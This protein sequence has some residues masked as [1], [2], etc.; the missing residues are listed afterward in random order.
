[1]LVEI[2][3]CMRFA[4]WYLVFGAA[5]ELSHVFAGL[6]LG[7]WPKMSWSNLL[8]I[9]LFRQ[10]QVKTSRAWQEVAIRHAGWLASVFIAVAMCTVCDSTARCAAI[11]T[12]AEA[13]LSDLCRL[14]RRR[15]PSTELGSL[16][17][18][19]WC[20]N[21]G[22]ILLNG[23]W[24]ATPEPMKDILQKMAEVTMVRG[25]QS[26]G[27]LSYV[28]NNN[29]FRSTGSDHWDLLGLRA[30]VVNQKRTCLSELLRTKLDRAERWAWLCR[31]KFVGSGRLYVGHTRFATSSKS[32][33]DGAHPHQW[34]PPQVYDVYTGFSENR[35]QKNK[36]HMEIFVTHNGDFDFFEFAGQ[37]HELAAVQAWLERVTWHAKPSE[38]D[39]AAIA[40]VL[41]LLRVQGCFALSARYGFLFGPCWMDLDCEVPTRKCCEQ[42]GAIMDAVLQRYLKKGLELDQLNIKRRCLYED[43]RTRLE[44]SG[45]K[46]PLKGRDL[47]Q[48]VRC[49]I[50][51]FF[52]NDLLQA[53]RLFMARARGS[54]GL[55]ITCSV[56]AH[57]QMILAAGGQSMSVAFYPRT[58][59]VLYA[60]E[61]AAV[62]AA[63][64]VC[65]PRPAAPAADVNDDNRDLEAARV[66]RT[67]SRLND[68]P[69]VRLDLDDLGGEICLLDWGRGLPSSA[70]GSFAPQPVMNH[71]MTITLVQDCF[72]QKSLACRLV[73]IEE[74]PLV[75]QL[76][77]AVQDPVG[78]D[79]ADI[80]DAVANIQVDFWGE[81]RPTRA[82]ARALGEVLLSRL[83][84]KSCGQLPATSVDILVTGCEVS[85]WVGEQ[86]AADLRT[87][88]HKLVVKSASA[89]KILGLFGQQFPMPQTGHEI[90][91]GW[92]LKDSIVLIV[93]HSGGT[94]APLAISNLMQSMTSNIFAVTSEW[95]TQIGKQL[96]QLNDLRGRVFSTEIG[97][98]PA[99][100][101]SLSVAA[102]HQMLTQILIYVASKIVANR[103]LSIAAGSKIKRIDLAELEKNN[104][105]NVQAL[106]A[107]A[108]S[109]E[110][111]N[112]ANE[113]RVL[114]RHWAQHV[115]E[116]PRAWMLSALYIFITVVYGSA[117]MTSATKAGM[118]GRFFEEELIYL[119]KL[120]DAAIYV[121]L[122]QIMI[123]LIRLM[124]QRPLLHRMT[125][126]T[127][128][129]GDVP[130]V[131]QT[132]ESFLSKLMACTY[133]ATGLIV[134]SAN[135]AD[136]MVHRMTHRVVRGTLLAVGRPDGRLTALSTAEQSVCM[137]VSQASS[138]QS[139]G[140]T[141]ESVTIGHN[142]HSLPL[143]ARAVFLED[144]RP[145]YLCEHLLSHHQTKLQGG[146]AVSILGAF[147][148]LAA[149]DAQEPAEVQHTLDHRRTRIIQQALDRQTQVEEKEQ[150]Q[151]VVDSLEVDEDGYV[152]F[153][154]C[155]RGF[156]LLRQ[157]VCQKAVRTIFQRL[158]SGCGGVSRADCK[159]IFNMQ[160]SSLRSLVDFEQMQ[161]RA[162]AGPGEDTEFESECTKVYE[163]LESVYGKS[164]L[165]HTASVAESLE[166][167]KTQNISMQL[168]ESRIASL[169]R[170]VAFFVIFHEMAAAIADFW[171]FVSFGYLGYRID[172]TQSIMRVA[173]TAS[174]VSGA[175]VRHMLIE[176]RVQGRLARMKV[177]LR[178]AIRNWR[179]RKSLRMRFERVYELGYATKQ[180][181][182]KG[183]PQNGLLSA[184][185]PRN[186]R[187]CSQFAQTPVQPVHPELSSG[188][189]VHD[190]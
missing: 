84:R 186:S 86:F 46:L 132:A 115:L 85:L 58:G 101:C 117:P 15:E 23:A 130:W 73:P 51:A 131:A 120:L 187:A 24:A 157:D 113:L 170:A 42:V 29:I 71:S 153:E 54:F 109:A 123:F 161:L 140:A 172:R 143:T 144:A 146:S 72:S 50:D 160:K 61:Q 177:L 78:A 12:A 124:Q 17:G 176:L 28:I 10:V 181:F 45:L 174:P 100:P 49:A 135:P 19:F 87:C 3:W 59:V 128:V 158:E 152:K 66:S 167:A 82:T 108:G 107:I 44:T 93:S 20:G 81:G 7:C 30:R 137:A 141:C 11:L 47:Q 26:G 164:L 41:E 184:A 90:G 106:R 88:F 9:L 173:T 79:I 27:V 60:S 114:G 57:R 91:E 133:S 136:H 125:T 89:N 155:W 13:C 110:H 92:D 127:V 185:A 80:P 70:S 149:E 166:L 1:M 102:T 139:L 95:D 62:K 69:A 151:A 169:Q 118:Q 40:G 150:A 111:H 83:Q 48:M 145:R 43:C 33:L 14:E 53:T 126:R 6:M 37:M 75:Q 16:D 99:E 31:Q 21:F 67:R 2:S 76:P 175:D 5:H 122:P 134:F 52:D 98:R 190:I 35:I 163:S 156:Q 121:F 178:T 34:S 171:S 165:D 39:S 68:G 94:F 188:V 38:V 147:Q 56:D 63:V 8:S 22:L 138:I 105:L 154:E 159:L 74:N 55:C 142:P 36:K 32:T 183:P 112:L 25:A 189:R 119:A 104:R 65:A 182:V 180:P 64:G 116:I 162:T 97:L 148:N 103:E 77:K 129:I 4:A 18:W 168:Y 96:R 179:R